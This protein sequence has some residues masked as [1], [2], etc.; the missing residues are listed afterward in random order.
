MN[1]KK[2]FPEKR[3]TKKGFLEFL[4]KKGFYIVLIL[5]IAIIG[6]TAVFMSTQGIT[7]SGDEPQAKIP[8]EPIEERLVD[9][10]DEGL[11]LD[12]NGKPSI[13]DK[14]PEEANRPVL[15]PQA[16]AEGA[17]AS[18]AEEPVL[19]E[20]NK[21][22]APKQQEKKQD[23]GKKTNPAGKKTDGTSAGSTGGAKFVMPVFGDITLGYA[24][25]E[26][27]YSKT[28]EEWRSHSGL[29]IAADRGTP[30]KAVNDGVVTEVKNDPRYG[31]MVVI[32]H[33]NGLKTVY[34]NLA[35]DEM[36]SPN[37]KVK[38]GEVIGAIGNTAVFESSEQSHLHF[39][40][41]K[42]NQPVNPKE[43]LPEK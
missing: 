14:E 5:C 35:S 38:Q 4:D 25:D 34:A 40:V 1:M 31:I 2:L 37:Q 8:Q 32:E 41:W 21:N 33:D 22:A 7:P 3:L 9:N 42:E 43:Y 20:N 13:A 16:N 30:V 17:T 39:E 11:S 24:E 29:D 27:V 12:E 36:A 19:A 15:N 23:E 28:L 18:D 26:L 6:A 10:Y